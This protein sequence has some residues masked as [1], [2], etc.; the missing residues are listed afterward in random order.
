MPTGATGDILESAL[1]GFDRMSPWDTIRYFQ[2]PV[3]GTISTAIPTPQVPFLTYDPMRIYVGFST[4]AATA[5]VAPVQLFGAYLGYIINS[6]SPILEFF[7]STHGR[8]CQGEWWV[9]GGAAGGQIQFTT[10]SLNKWP[11]E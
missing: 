9:T 2:L 3:T 6:Q 8:L 1:R 4:A 5:S 10:L 7:H 11:G